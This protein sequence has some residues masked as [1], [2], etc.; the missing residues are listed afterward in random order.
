MNLIKFQR[1][2]GRQS[3]CRHCQE[4]ILAG[5]PRVQGVGPGYG[6]R[7]VIIYFHPGCARKIIET[8]MELDGEILTELVAF[9]HARAQAQEA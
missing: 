7:A 8:R 3:K 6:G 5:A 4:N 2:G 9:E 1:D